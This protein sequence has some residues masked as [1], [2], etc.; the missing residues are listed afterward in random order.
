MFTGSYDNIPTQQLN[1]AADQSSGSPL[2][3]IVY[4]ILARHNKQLHSFNAKDPQ[5]KTHGITLRYIKNK[6]TLPLP[7]SKLFAFPT[8]ETA[9]NWLSLSIIDDIKKYAFVKGFTTK[10]II[11][12]SI[13]IV[14]NFHQPKDKINSF[15]LQY[16]SY[17]NNKSSL[18]GDCEPQPLPPNTIFI[19]NFT[20]LE[21]IP[22]SKVLD[23]K[24]QQLQN[25]Y[26]S[27]N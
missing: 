4:K 3:I 7:N 6:Q 26:A 8:L 22:H 25:L 20:P 27:Y 19:D 5:C 1:Q 15:W 10:P 11:K 24:I 18:I 2:P 9:I 17:P 21:I 12:P 16:N 13:D 14:P 23:I